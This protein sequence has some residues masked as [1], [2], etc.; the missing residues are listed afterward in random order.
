M[1]ALPRLGVVPDLN[2]RRAAQVDAAVALGTDLVV[3]QQLDV[4]VVLV[5]GEVG[6][7]AVVD[8][9]AVLDPPV[10]LHVLGALASTLAFSSDASASNLRGSIVFT[11]CQPLKS[12]PLKRGVSGLL[13]S[14]AERAWQR[15]CRHAQNQ[16]DR[17]FIVHCV[18]LSI[19]EESGLC[20]VGRIGPAA[21]GGSLRDP[22][23]R[24][25]GAGSTV[26][27]AGVIDANPGVTADQ[28]AGFGLPASIRASTEVQIAAQRRRAS[29]GRAAS[30]AGS[31][32]D[33]IRHGAPAAQ[34]RGDWARSRSFP[35]SIR[36][37]QRARSAWSQ[38]MALARSRSRVSWSGGGS[39]LPCPLAARAAEQ[40]A[41]K[42]WPALGSS[43][44]LGD[45][46]KVSSQ[47][48]AEAA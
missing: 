38:S 31:Q 34:P 37:V 5:G 28:A 42:R 9:L 39:S 12:L 24:D 8:D 40:A 3:D 43:A 35:V 10:L 45:A 2:L 15:P 11:P 19:F 21:V 26:W 18:D 27:R 48:R 1:L 32:A 16:E 14:L 22:F 33:Q 41:A 13:S 17:Q 25:D 46:V 36:A 47:R 29:S 4:A 7:L 30:A 20:V 6:A 44:N 23:C